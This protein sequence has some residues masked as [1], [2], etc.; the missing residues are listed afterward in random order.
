MLA[1][2][3][4]GP[5]TGVPISLLWGLCMYY[6][7]TKR[8]LDLLVS[9]IAG[10]KRM[11]MSVRTGFAESSVSCLGPVHGIQQGAPLPPRFLYRSHDEI[12]YILHGDPIK[13]WVPGKRSIV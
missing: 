1:W 8:D 2:Y 4:P 11:R 12:G 9:A 3:I 5:L 13:N 6:I 7:Y 10:H